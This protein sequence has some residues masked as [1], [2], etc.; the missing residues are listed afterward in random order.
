M[1]SLSE[2]N[3]L[4]PLKEDVETEFMLGFTVPIL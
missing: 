4:L 3:I 2:N 1:P